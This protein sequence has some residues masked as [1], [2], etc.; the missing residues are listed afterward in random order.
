MLGAGSR[1]ARDFAFS[2]MELA[3]MLMKH[4]NSANGVAT[5]RRTNQNDVIRDVPQIPS[6]DFV[7]AG[8]AS[9]QNRSRLS[10]LRARLE[11]RTRPY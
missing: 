5:S 10:L 3:R 9:T 6:G 2:K 8:E 11:P 4:H 7:H 1:R